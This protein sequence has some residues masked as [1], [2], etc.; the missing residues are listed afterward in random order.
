LVLNDPQQPGRELGFSVELIDVLE[1]LPA[2]VLGFFL[3]FAV[4]PEDGR[5]QVYAS[6]TMTENQLVERFSIT[7]LCQIDQLLVCRNGATKSFHGCG[8]KQVPGHDTVMDVS[9]SVSTKSAD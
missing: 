6:T 3:P 2:C 4:V 5:G 1:C 8:N 7:L 9:F